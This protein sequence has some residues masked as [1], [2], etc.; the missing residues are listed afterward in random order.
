MKVLEECGLYKECEEVCVGIAGNACTRDWFAKYPKV[1]ILYK[2]PDPTVYESLTLQHLYQ[3]AKALS[4]SDYLVLYFHTKGA[5]SQFVNNAR[6]VVMWRRV[7][8]Y[9]LVTNYKRCIELIQTHH[10]DVLGGNFIDQIPQE[11]LRDMLCQGRTHAC[12]Y[13]GNFWWA[14]T[15]YISR[16]H[17]PEVHTATQNPNTHHHLRLLC[18]NWVLSLFPD[19]RAGECFRYS[20]PHPYSRPWNLHDCDGKFV[21]L[22]KNKT[23]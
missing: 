5:H 12:H 22:A 13:S 2:N 4:S 17:K 8:G 16:L 21:I 6:A 10:L 9:W 3:R 1:R 19:V 11:G 23:K 7:M 18:E 14:R 20:D 15:T